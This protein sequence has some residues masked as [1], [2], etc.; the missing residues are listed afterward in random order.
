M[1]EWYPTLQMWG[2]IITQILRHRTTAS[3]F[4]LIIYDVFLCLVFLLISP[5]I[6]RLLNNRVLT[7]FLL[8][9]P[10]S[11]LLLRKT[12]SCWLQEQTLPLRSQPLSTMPPQVFAPVSSN[13]VPSI[14]QDIH[15]LSQIMYSGLL[16]P[17]KHHTLVCSPH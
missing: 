15:P 17:K 9:I 11:F 1:C 12:V 2:H 13:G 5:R 7:S 14:P 8:H 16:R 4:P 10:L 6:S 3:L